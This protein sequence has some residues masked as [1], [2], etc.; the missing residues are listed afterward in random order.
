MYRHA[1]RGLPSMYVSRRQSTMMTSAVAV[2]EVRDA[3]DANATFHA[4]SDRSTG[5]SAADPA[6]TPSIKSRN[7]P[8]KLGRAILHA[9]RTPGLLAQSRA[10][11]TTVSHASLFDNPS[12]RRYKESSKKKKSARQRLVSWLSSVWVIS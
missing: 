11:A 1:Q 7:R 4:S 8:P 2:Y 3:S 5:G 6:T 9:A 10:P 12:S